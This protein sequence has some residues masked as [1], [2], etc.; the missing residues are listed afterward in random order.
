MRQNNK[1]GWQSEGI[2]DDFHVDGERDE[3]KLSNVEIDKNYKFRIKNPIAKFFA[4]LFYCFAINLP[5]LF[6]KI[7]YHNIFVLVTNK[8]II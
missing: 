8:I 5:F 2:S 4:N 1:K 7:F 3:S 6:T